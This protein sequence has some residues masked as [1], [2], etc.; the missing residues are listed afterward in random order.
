MFSLSIHSVSVAHKFLYS[1]LS[2]SS[3]VVVVVADFI[4]CYEFYPFVFAKYETE[5]FVSHNFCK[6]QVENFEN[7]GKSTYTT[8]NSAFA[9][10]ESESVIVYTQHNNFFFLLFSLFLCFFEKKKRIQ[11]DTSFIP[12]M[13][14]VKFEANEIISLHQ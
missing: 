7:D 2:S 11:F 9:G 6:I 4:V 5:Q 12:N 14:L 3:N 13:S 10:V 8:I 1:V